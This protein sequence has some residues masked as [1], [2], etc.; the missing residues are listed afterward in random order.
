MVLV[1][2]RGTASHPE[3]EVDGSDFMKKQRAIG[4]SSRY[5]NRIVWPLEVS[6]A[7]IL[8]EARLQTILRNR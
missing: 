8:A 1:L 3:A 6:V 7:R 5:E 4:S 2:A